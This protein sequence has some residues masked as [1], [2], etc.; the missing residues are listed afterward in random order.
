ML[1]LGSFIAVFLRC[2]AVGPAPHGPSS[3][4]K[5]VSSPPGV[6][7]DPRDSLITVPALTACMTSLNS[8]AAVGCREA[9]QVCVM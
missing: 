8:C 3:H 2:G 7:S 6:A 4:P 5:E 9:L 1:Q